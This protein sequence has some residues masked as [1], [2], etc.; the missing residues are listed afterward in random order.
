MSVTPCTVKQKEGLCLWVWDH[1]KATI[2]CRFAVEGRVCYIRCFSSFHMLL[3]RASVLE[4]QNTSPDPYWSIIEGK[5][6]AIDKLHPL[7]K[8]S[9]GLHWAFVP[10]SR[11]RHRALMGHSD[12]AAIATERAACP[13]CTF[14]FCHICIHVHCSPHKSTACYSRL[15]FCDLQ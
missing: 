11:S 8:E 13:F 10:R 14:I 9:A 3:W 7:Q 6:M 15:C 2:W 4:E 12:W 5:R 1:W